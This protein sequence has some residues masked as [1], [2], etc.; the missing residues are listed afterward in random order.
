MHRSCNPSTARKSL[1][2]I[3]GI[4]PCSIEGVVRASDSLIFCAIASIV[5]PYWH[6]NKIDKTKSERRTPQWDR[7]AA[8]MLKVS[9]KSVS[10]I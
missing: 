6:H 2:S 4:K 3:C 8:W 5:C 7:D 10:S 1:T 9:L